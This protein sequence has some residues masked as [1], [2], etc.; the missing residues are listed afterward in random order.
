LNLE[1]EIRMLESDAGRAEAEVVP[2]YLGAHAVRQNFS[3]PSRCSSMRV[4]DDLETIAERKLRNSATH[5]SSPASLLPEKDGAFPESEVSGMHI[6]FH[7]DEFNR[8]A[9]PNWPSNWSHIG[10]SPG[11]DQRAGIERIAASEGCR[12]SSRDI[13]CLRSHYVPAANSL[14]AA[15]RWR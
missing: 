5:S 9:A 12:L 10:R 1:T 3:Q 2:T 4:I 14:S 13:S 11:R 15:P 6:K 8:R 7:A